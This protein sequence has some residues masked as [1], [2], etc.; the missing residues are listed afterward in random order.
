MA[1]FIIPSPP[2]PWLFSDADAPRDLRNYLENALHVPELPSHM[3]YYDSS[4][5]N[6]YKICS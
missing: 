6:M 1:V 2:P 3:K 4:M 5:K